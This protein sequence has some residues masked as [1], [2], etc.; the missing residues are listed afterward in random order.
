MFPKS[1]YTQQIYRRTKYFIFQIYLEN[2]NLQPDNTIPP[3]FKQTWSCTMDKNPK[4]VARGEFQG[5]C[6][7]LLDKVQDT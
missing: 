4:N 3:Y 7:T 5:S 1:V 6:N 2:F